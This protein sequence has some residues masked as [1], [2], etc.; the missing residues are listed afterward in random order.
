MARLEDLKDGG[1]IPSSWKGKGQLLKEESQEGIVM[2]PSDDENDEV[3]KQSL[4]PI[5]VLDDN[6]N[7]VAME[8]SGSF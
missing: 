5:E 2:W 8:S 1:H 6:D 3:E 7:D 4:P